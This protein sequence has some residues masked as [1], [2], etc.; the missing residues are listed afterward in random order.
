MKEILTKLVEA[1]GPPG[2]EAQV[3]ELII[4][5]IK[6]K[7]DDIQI[8]VMGNIIAKKKG[9]IGEKSIMFAAH[10]DEIG[11]M[12]THIDK[13][14]FLRFTTMGGVKVFNLIGERVR[15]ANGTIGVI[16]AEFIKNWKEIELHKLFID[17]GVE[18]KEEAQK[19]VAIGDSCGIERSLV[20][21][22][23][24]VA[25]K[26]LDDRIGCAILIQM[27]NE[28]QE[29][30]H[31]HDVYFTF[32]VQEEVGLRGAKTAAYGID[33]DL[34]IAVDVTIA[35]DTPE[36]P[37]IDLHLGKGPAIKVKDVSMITNPLVKDLMVNTAKKHNIPYQLEVLPYGG[38][39]AGAIH[40]T[41]AG[42]LA[43]CISIPCRYVHSPSEMVDMRDVEHSVKLGLQ[44][45]KEFV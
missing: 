20:D 31:N 33:P 21:L 38:T 24:R 43:G 16:N 45:I 13:N 8:D 1:Y 6:A 32:T 42:I 35:G 5:E 25:A 39:D 34:G 15:F 36:P 40:L 4:N 22:G 44:L 17:I 41:K 10:M 26:S 9:N 28:I 7:V 37:K 18:T 19:L 2:N 29:I 27:I 11:L 3:R 14:G 30:S 23:N 12:V